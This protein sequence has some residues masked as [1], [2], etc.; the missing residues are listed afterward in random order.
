MRAGTPPDEGVLL[1]ES[2][3][4]LFLEGEPLRRELE[5]TI[6]VPNRPLHELLAEWHS[7]E[8]IG[9]VARGKVYPAA[10]HRIWGA[11]ETDGG[12]CWIRT[13]NFHLVTMAL[14]R[15]S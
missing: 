7:T 12:P 13:S 6:A 11:R 15:L 4:C 10:A 9:V 8:R 5:V 1:A 14:Y 3:P 2:P